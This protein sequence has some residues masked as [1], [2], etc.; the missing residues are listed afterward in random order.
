MTEA[1]IAAL[2][3][4]ARYA[5]DC[6]VSGNFEAAVKNAIFAGYRAGTNDAA[7][8]CADEAA[9]L[10]RLGAEARQQMLN[11]LHFYLQAELVDRI[12]QRVKSVHPK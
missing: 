12:E 8:V 9:T 1:E 5:T 4:E 6:P 2:V 10:R 11:E 7:R 3:Q